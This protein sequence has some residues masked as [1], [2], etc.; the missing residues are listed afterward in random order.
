MLAQICGAAC[1]RQR[2]PA[3]AGRRNHGLAFCFGVLIGKTCAFITYGPDAS[4][5]AAP[6]PPVTYRAV[7]APYISLRPAKPSGLVPQSPAPATG[8]SHKEGP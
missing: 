7:T 1:S 6:V 8:H 2:F 3:L 5:P 4:D